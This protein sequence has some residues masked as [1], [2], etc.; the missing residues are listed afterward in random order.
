VKN[1]VLAQ[2]TGYAP[3]LQNNRHFQKGKV[4]SAHLFLVFSQNPKI[5]I[6]NGIWVIAPSKT[7]SR[8]DTLSPRPGYNGFPRARR[9]C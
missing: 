4:I 5:V 2:P 1:A 6:E 7:A 8:G 3:Y 9:V